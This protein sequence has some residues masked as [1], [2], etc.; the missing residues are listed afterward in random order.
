MPYVYRDPSVTKLWKLMNM[1]VKNRLGSVDGVAGYWQDDRVQIA[2][3]TTVESKKTSRR[4]AYSP[5]FAGQ[6]PDHEHCGGSGFQC[7][8]LNV[9]IFIRLCIALLYILLR[10]YIMYAYE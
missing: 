5:C 3:K 10:V 6:W 8:R 2:E 1:T 7:G 9:H 4:L